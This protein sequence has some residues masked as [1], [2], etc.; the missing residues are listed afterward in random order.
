M[1]SK[2]DRHLL[3]SALFVA[4]VM[5]ALV[6][7][8][9]AQTTIN[10][11]FD[12]SANMLTL[13][14][15][16]NITA[17]LQEGGRTWASRITIDG[18]RSIE[19]VVAID[20]EP[21]V[22]AASLTTSYI[23]QI[24]GRA[25]YEQGVAHELRT[26]IDPNGAAPD[27]LITFGLDYLHNELWF[28]PDPAARTAPVPANRTDA[29]SAVLHE[30]G[31]MIAYNGWANRNDGSPMHFDYWSVFDAWILSGSAPSFG[32]P[33]AVAAWSD[34]P[35]ALTKGDINHW[36]NWGQAKAMAGG[37]QPLC[38]DA[39]V[40]LQDGVPVPRLCAVAPSVDFSAR[41]QIQASADANLLD[42]V[43]H[44]VVTYRGMRYYISA[45]DLGVLQD[46]GLIGD[47]IFA[48]GFDGS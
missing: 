27:A 26:G 21:T 18:P 48:S 32:G 35:P 23:R 39:P 15:R 45:L 30:F 5:L 10:V 11:T 14:E 4:V 40:A 37:S 38:S 13:A 44:G 20:D 12:S 3:A 7:P 22:S 29:M 41:E 46:V 31:H 8:A 47:S 43:M 16:D 33:A 25:T 42:Q 9:W 28:D 19:V 36:G 1:Q 6:H 34:T 24:D 2:D 17:E